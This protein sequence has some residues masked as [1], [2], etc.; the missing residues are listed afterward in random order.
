[1][2]LAALQQGGFWSACCVCRQAAHAVHEP[3]LTGPEYDLVLLMLLVDS[4]EVDVEMYIR[5]LLLYSVLNTLMCL[6]AAC[7]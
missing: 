1:M 3:G 6:W 2:H 4:S 7:M 5:I